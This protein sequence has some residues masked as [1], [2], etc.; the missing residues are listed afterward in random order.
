MKNV[1][2][3]VSRCNPLI[4]LPNSQPVD[5]AQR[6]HDAQLIH[7]LSFHPRPLV[8]NHQSQK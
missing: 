8:E 3:R 5:S 1:L 4:F 7:G 2:S 6:S